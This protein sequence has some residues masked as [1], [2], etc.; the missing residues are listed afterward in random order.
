MKK[1]GNTETRGVAIWKG[2]EVRW[3]E[4]F[5]RA[6]IMSEKD[7]Q[8]PFQKECVCVCV[9]DGEGHYD[10]G[11]Q[12]SKTQQWKRILEDTADTSTWERPYNIL[13]R[14]MLKSKEKGQR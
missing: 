7:K 9:L 8:V 3:E 11:S 13:S 2:L 10:R 1:Q 5:C 6:W 4:V 12:L 14:L